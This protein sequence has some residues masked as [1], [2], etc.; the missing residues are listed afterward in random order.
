[1]NK[2]LICQN[3]INEVIDLLNLFS[4]QSIICEQC[5]NQLTFNHQTRRCKKCLKIMSEEEETCLDCQWL[6]NKYPLINQ[7]YTLYDYDGLVKA[8]IQQ[9]KLNGDV[10][11]NQVFQ[12][13]LKL[14]KRYD[15]V[16]PAPIHPNK[17]EQRTFD[18]VT[19]VLDNHK[20]KYIQVFGTEERKKQSELTKIER[21]SQHN[22]FKI[23]KDIDF[24]NKR[25]LLVDDIYTT[26][27]TMHRL[28]ELLFIRKIRKIDALTF[29]RAVNNDKI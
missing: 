27:L 17:L 16:I 29:A 21:S 11:L 5:A 1:M 7:L 20:I 4:K 3:N 8:L 13:P 24:E 23:N 28:A 14:F 9:Y 18:H 2:C 12:L 26:G 15:Y 22:P 6:S 19:T 10:A 25:I